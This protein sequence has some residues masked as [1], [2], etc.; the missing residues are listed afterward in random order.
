MSVSATAVAEATALA[1][2]IVEVMVA[3]K[4]GLWMTAVSESEIIER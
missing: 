2:D 1:D 4:P 3:G